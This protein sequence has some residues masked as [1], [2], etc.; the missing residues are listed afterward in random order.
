MI[1]TDTSTMFMQFDP[2][3]IQNVTA[4]LFFATK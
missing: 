2:E 3:N 1:N 4:R